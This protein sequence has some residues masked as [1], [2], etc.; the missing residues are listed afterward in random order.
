MIIGGC[1]MVGREMRHTQMS[2][3]FTVDYE[4]MLILFGDY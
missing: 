4:K 2:G 3:G 1:M